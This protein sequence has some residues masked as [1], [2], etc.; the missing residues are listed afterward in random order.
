MINV[1]PNAYDAPG[2]ATSGL[3]GQRQTPTCNQIILHG[4]APNGAGHGMIPNTG[5]IY[6]LR[7]PTASGS[8]NYDDTGVIVGI[9]EPG[10]GSYNLPPS[11][12]LPVTS[13][14]PY[15]YYV[16]ADV[17][18]EGVVPVLWGVG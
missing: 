11:G 15:R 5:R 12:G 3:G 6:I 13:L 14:S 4:Y 9:I 10:G 2:T 8:G 18:G 1:D 17:E 16:D 7:A